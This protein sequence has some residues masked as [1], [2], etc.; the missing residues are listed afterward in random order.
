MG[1]GR[2]EAVDG[3]RRRRLGGVAHGGRR[4]GRPGDHGSV[5]SG[6]RARAVRL[7]VKPGA[8]R[9]IRPFPW[10]FAV[11]G[12]GRREREGRE[13]VSGSFVIRPKF[14]NPVL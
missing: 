6:G 3:E 14:Q 7:R 8:R 5:A 4:G 2:A 13:M 1:S 12:Y 10:R 11:A 9:P